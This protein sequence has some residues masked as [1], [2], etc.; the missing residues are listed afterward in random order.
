MVRKLIKNEFLDSVKNFKPVL[1]LIAGIVGIVVLL[2]FT[3]PSLSDNTFFPALL[4]FVIYA[5]VIAI[6]V[7]TILSFIQLLYKSLYK[8]ESYRLFT[9]PVGVEEILI[10]KVVVSFI[11]TAIISL[12]SFLAVTFIILFILGDIP[13]FT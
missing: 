11:W 7:L 6:V 8:R 2:K 3:A 12:A 4:V 13:E 9:L 5:F 1:L 10:S